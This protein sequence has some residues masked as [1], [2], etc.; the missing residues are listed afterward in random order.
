MK[1]FALCGCRSLLG[2]SL[3]IIA[4][5]LGAIGS[6]TNALSLQTAADEWKAPARQARRQNPVPS[7]EKSIAQ[8]KLIYQ[9][10]CLPCHGTT[11]K[12]DGPAAKDLPKKS[13]DLSDAK[14]W[15]QS[16]GALFWK[17]TEGRSPMPGFE[18][19]LSDDNDRWKVINYIRTLAP[20]PKEGEKK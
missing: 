11:G 7:D 16:D 17:I 20:K 1:H 12:G 18:K 5:L 19:L 15:M 8:G 4:L 9:Q 10:Q 14:M 3:V 2:T 13:G 6:M